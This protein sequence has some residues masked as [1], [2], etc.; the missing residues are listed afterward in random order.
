MS[1]QFETQLA[2]WL[3]ERLAENPPQAGQ[4]LLAEFHDPATA[5]VFAD[6]LQ[7]LAAAEPR[8]IPGSS[9]TLPTLT[10]EDGVPLFLARVVPEAP[11]DSPAHVITQG[12]ATRMR[13]LV[14]DSAQT[15]T[16][17]AMLMVLESDATLDTLE[18]S[19]SLF[20]EEGSLNLTSFRESVLDPETCSSE[21]GK[22]LLKA[23]NKVLS[24]DSLYSED[25]EVLDTL[26]EIRLAIDEEDAD[27]LPELI[28]ELPGFIREDYIESDWF[29]QTT[30]EE[31][32]TDSA[33]EFL[34]DNQTHAR[35]LRRA[36]RTGTDTASKLDSQYEEGFVRGVL[37]RASWKDTSHTRAAKH[38]IKRTSRQFRT[39]EVDAADT[40][41]YSPVDESGVRRAIVAIADDGEVRLTAEFSAD[42]DDVP[43]EFLDSDGNES[44]LAT[45]SKRENRLTARLEGLASDRPFY[46][47]LLLY[48]GNQTTRGTPTHE[49]D[50]AVVPSWIFEATKDTPF[51]VDVEAETLIRHGDEEI[52]LQPPQRLDFDFS[53]EQTEVTVA[54]GDERS[55]E[56]TG[57]LVINP[58]APD[59]VERVSILVAPPDEIPIRITFLTEVSTADT[60][61]MIFPL[62][63]AGI[64]EPDRWAGEALQ[65]P[66]SIS[67]DTNR[68]EIYTPTEEGI[69]IEEAPLE[70]IQ[71]EEEIIR[72]REVQHR[73]IDSEELQ[74]GRVADGTALE[75]FPEL[76]RAYARLLEHFDD[77]NR[78]PSTDPWDEETKRLVDDVLTAYEASIDEIG[79]TPDFSDYT[80]IRG[81]GT[82][83]ST[84]SNRIWLTPF[85]PVMLA[86]GYRIAAWRDDTLVAN[87][88]VGGFRSERFLTRFNPTGLLPYMVS[89]GADKELLRGL[90]YE[91]NPLWT[92]Y[93]PI[94]S[95]GSVTPQYMERV[96]RDKLDTFMHSFPLLFELHEGRNFVI[97]LVNMGDL[98]PVIKGLYEFYKRVE[99]SRFE[100]PQILLRIYGGPAEG[101]SLDRFFGDSAQSR[102]RIQLEQKNDEVVDLLRS[103]LMYVREG[104]YSEANHKEAHITLFRGLL[105]EDAGI[106]ELGDLPSG[107]LLDGLLPR[108]SIDVQSGASGTVYS[109]GFGGHGDDESLV[110]S[111]ARVA[112]T[113]E[114]GRLNNNY[115]PDHT[116]KKTIK[117]A[118]RA[119]LGKLWDDSLWV[120]HVQPNVGLEFYI[121]SDSE[122]G[123]G[124]GMVMIHYND[125]YD[126]SS[127]N[128]DVITSTTKQNPYLTAL[129]RALDEADLA[130][131]LDASTVLSMLIAVDGELALDLQQSDDKGV[132][133]KAGF[134][135]GLA[136]SK[137]LLDENSEGYTWVPLSLNELSRHDRATR[138]GTDGLLQY[139]ESGAA[140]DD[141]CMVGVP[142]NL[143]GNS[144]Q[145]WIVETKGGTS[146]LKKGREQVEGAIS[147]LRS[148]FHPDIDYSDAQ[149]LYSEFGKT[150]LDVARRMESYDVLEEAE[151]STIERNETA[152][153]EGDF[154]V[155]FLTDATGHI[156]EV[157]RVRSDTL[158]CDVDLSHE[159]RT[160][161]A[162]L[163]T[164]NLLGEGS[165]A[166][167]LPD[168]NPDQLS[169]DLPAPTEVQEGETATPS[170]DT[171]ASATTSTASEETAAPP[172]TDHSSH[173]GTNEAP[174]GSIETAE[175]T[176]AQGMATGPSDPAQNGGGR[177]TDSG[178]SSQ[179]QSGDPDETSTSAA[180]DA[181]EA[182]SEPPDNGKSGSAQSTDEPG[183]NV[184]PTE[185]SSTAD[186]EPQPTS[187]TGQDASS[188]SSEEAEVLPRAGTD[189]DSI[190]AEMEQSE[191]P[192]ADIDR[193][194]L[195]QDL[196][197]EF[198]SLGVRIH[199]PN[200]SSISIGPRKIGVNVHPKEGQ[201]VEGIMQKLN[202]LSVHIQA[203]GD[204]VGS[205]NPS[206]GAVRLEIPHS[207]P[208]TVFLR[209]GIEALRSELAEP[210]TIPLGVD[211]DNQHHALSMLQEKHALVGGATGSG[212]SN[213]LSTIVANFAITHSPD[214][215]KM[216]ILDPKGVDFGRFADLPHVERGTYLDT[217]DACTDHLIELLNTELP[218]RKQRL[219]ESGFASVSELN[220]YA[221]EMGHEP[222]PYHVIIIDEYADLIMSLDDND[223]AFE[224]AV[225]RLAQVGR[226]HG[227]VIFLATQRPSADIVSGKI[228]ANF[229]C[230]ISF[231][232]PSNTDSRVILDEPG[233]EDLQGAGDMIVLTQDGKLRLQGYR[234]SP[235][236]A[237]AI[238]KAYTDSEE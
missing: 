6:S 13:N 186:P 38:E 143:D 81:L 66:E 222:M 22:A 196:K 227:F 204:I 20:G 173:S 220:E 224:E 19:E 148:I 47:R 168:L 44:D 57:Y 172:S 80:S 56:F 200:P 65:L 136:L 100:P 164:L 14:S 8:E 112:N 45:L 77:R 88:A 205:P 135:G 71:T 35:Q 111:V 3:Q 139:T 159:V 24:S 128:Y 28:G 72:S 184:T 107:M 74:A 121:E 119:D 23:L 78:T 55:V 91:E 27:R 15:D 7:K 62:M 87:G 73:V 170:T 40:R 39:L 211:V 129:K 132:I 106:T 166:D 109:V 138:D 188:T 228:K 183:D 64:A 149:L 75:E 41:I 140:S 51:D 54:D 155:E 50:V 79:D 161:N 195:V 84:V 215:L 226:A 11:A 162:P 137:Q 147:E 70:I 94:E 18:A 236:D 21:Q 151:A 43:Y 26:C 154:A 92:V 82:I 1:G 216:S 37:D 36:H 102:L 99:K 193:S 17:F 48:V 131:Y 201:T 235:K 83:R 160:I 141:I 115:L 60:E 76:Q 194:K 34:A 230:R 182:T 197:R 127:P 213:F 110:E 52:T 192:E 30:P 158:A 86:Y 4:K 67:I 238:R 177:T 108:E 185:A 171:E 229:P 114:A 104:E 214:D 165:V 207:E 231:R 218:E 53:E 9:A 191:E 90:L 145:L 63:L 118:H 113:L 187:D 85:H 96:V 122:I 29:D 61:E 93:S 120:V 46:G 175:Q 232:L 221:E 225:T 237:I 144:I 180:D 103:N 2:E 117:S 176:G 181:V 105:T 212:K 156:G 125:Q 25:V 199:P 234:L 133:E 69:R 219:Q 179:D 31:D 203:E 12:F 58:S 157:I 116:L 208:T 95:P 101:E 16:P 178:S 167:V 10:V 89:D 206:K 130:G 59:T 49:F 209:D 163:K 146:S 174:D 190:L 68:G 124:G 123:A 126:T 223:D 153:M 98:R 202:S 134:V 42:L 142:D 33:A 233:A 32:L 198:E 210:V 169:L 5:D 97:N 217:P 189:A 152:L 150:V